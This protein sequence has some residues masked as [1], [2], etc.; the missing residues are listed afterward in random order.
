MYAFPRLTMPAGAVE[1]AAAQHK[2]PDFVYCMELLD[3]TGI[4]TV[5]GSGFWQVRVEGCCP[6]ACTSALHQAAR[7]PDCRLPQPLPCFATPVRMR[8]RHQLSRRPFL[9]LLLAHAGARHLPC[10]HYHPAAGGRHGGG[11]P[12]VCRV[13]RR[14]HAAVW[15]DERLHLTQ[16]IADRDCLAAASWDVWVPPLRLVRLRAVAAGRLLPG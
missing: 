13:P 15:Q 6:C 4:V 8:P 7:V 12:K 10:A 9:L 5:P 2:Q 14:I 3:Q 16:L 11:V 1:A